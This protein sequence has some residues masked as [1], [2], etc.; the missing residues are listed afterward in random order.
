M[1]PMRRLTIALVA[2][3]CLGCG[4]D[5]PTSLD[6]GL[7]SPSIDRL[8]IFARNWPDEDV[9]LVLIRDAGQSTMSLFRQ[10]HEGQPRVVLDSI[11]PGPLDA[12]REE[13][14]TLLASFDVWALN[15]PNAPGAACQTVNGARTCYPTFEDYSLVMRVESGGEVR[16]QRYTGL[17]KSTAVPSA[18]ALADFVL[19]WARRHDGGGPHRLRPG[20]AAVHAGLSSRSPA[21][22][23]GR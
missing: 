1:T 2:A 14:R 5:A 3:C 17:E 11:G 23:V 19:G 9:T 21:V 20:G 18:R 16:V 12:E 6:E 4:D 13:I 8:Y 22:R 15:A 10:E 7:A